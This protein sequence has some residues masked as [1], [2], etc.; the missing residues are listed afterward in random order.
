MGGATV[1]PAGAHAPAFTDWLQGCAARIERAGDVWRFTLF[2]RPAR[3][4]DVY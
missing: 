1:S 4:G 3:L 2:R